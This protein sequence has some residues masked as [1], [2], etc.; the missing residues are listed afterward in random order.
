MDA[1][2]SAHRQS[3][4]TLCI[5][6][7]LGLAILFG[8]SSATLAKGKKLCNSVNKDSY[9]C[10]QCDLQSRGAGSCLDQNITDIEKYPSQSH[11]VKCGSGGKQCCIV[12]SKGKEISCRSI[13]NVNPPIVGPGVVAP[14]VLPGTLD[15]GPRHPST[16]PFSK[17]TM[18]GP[19]FHRGV[20]GGKE[21]PDKAN[22][23][24]TGQDGK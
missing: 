4:K 22:P 16:A 10:T 18:K 8:S 5:V 21:D 24:G 9:G 15:P 11:V 23:S 20:E 17:P 1:I 19:I 6:C 13:S 7:M 2:V 12:D 14:P 3:I